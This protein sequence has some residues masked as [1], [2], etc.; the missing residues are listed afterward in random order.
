ML[1][2]ITLTVTAVMATN[3]GAAAPATPATPGAASAPGV[4]AVTDTLGPTMS[5][6]GLDYEAGVVLISTSESTFHE[7]VEI[8]KDRTGVVVRAEDDRTVM[9]ADGVA[10]SGHNEPQIVVS[11]R[12]MF[13][14]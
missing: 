11:T 1:A 12:E 6:Y 10:V 3:V 13:E 8:I 14:E 9:T 7:V 2:S 5:S 4:A